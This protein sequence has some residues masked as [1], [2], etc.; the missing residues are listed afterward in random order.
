MK[1]SPELLNR[2]GT[3]EVA[4]F[5]K[6]RRLVETWHE[7]KYIGVEIIGAEDLET[8]ETLKFKVYVYKVG[9]ARGME[10]VPGGF[11]I[12]M[13]KPVEMWKRVD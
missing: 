9:V 3:I 10:K 12:R 13:S 7:A 2:M 11:W 6:Q 5:D 4:V 8:H 1:I